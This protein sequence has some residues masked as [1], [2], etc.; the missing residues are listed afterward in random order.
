MTTTLIF[1]R[2]CEADGNINRVFHGHTDSQISENGRRQLLLLSDRFKSVRFDRIC[3][4]PLIR[5][6]LTAQAVNSSLMLPIEPCGG[7][8]EINGGHWE[9]KRW[10]DLPFLY[11]QESYD[12][13]KAPH[14]F[15]PEGG[16]SMR[17]L[18]ERIS[19]TAADIAGRN[20]GKT[21]VCVSHGCAIRNLICWAKGMPIERLDEVPWGENT[22]VSILEFDE[23][24]RPGLVLENDC[25]HLSDEVKTLARQDWWK[26]DKLEEMFY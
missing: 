20:T 15:S 3:S 12:W 14:N 10:R 17:R 2:H 23:H 1:V 7:L 16:E 11:P 24:M 13:A 25:S 9:G 19:R 6:M 4:S 18:R 5:A 8:I 26:K 22:A 21:I